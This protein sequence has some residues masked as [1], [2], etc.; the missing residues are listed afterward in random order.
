MRDL[1]PDPWKPIKGTGDQIDH[2]EQQD[3]AEPPWM[4]HIE[5]VKKVQHLIEANP[6][7][8]NIF[9]TGSI[10]CDQRTDDGKDRKQNEEKDR[11][12]KW[13]EKIIE[14]A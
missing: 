6:E 13:S 7:S 10:L 2:Q 3:R 11:E 1:S 9:R 5:E 4:I 12:F 14:D 8:L